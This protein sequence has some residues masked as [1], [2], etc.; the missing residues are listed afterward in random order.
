MSLSQ[1]YSHFTSERYF[2]GHTFSALCFNLVSSITVK[3]SSTLCLNTSTDGELTTTPEGVHSISGQFWDLEL[4]ARVFLSREHLPISPSWT[5]CA[6]TEHVE[7]LRCL[8][9]LQILGGEPHVSPNCLASG[10]WFLAL[11]LVTFALCAF[12]SLL[13][14]RTWSPVSHSGYRMRSPGSMHR[15]QCRV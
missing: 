15:Q 10:T 12:V 13:L 1:S 11:S 4:C 7:T 8:V 2:R 6:Y 14:W 3:W 9:L 5:H